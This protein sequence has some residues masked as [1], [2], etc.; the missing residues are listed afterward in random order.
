[1]ENKIIIFG[2]PVAKQRAR[3]VNGRAF[4][5]QKTK[6]Y[7][8]K[9]AWEYKR[10]KGKFFGDKPVKVKIELFFAPPKS[11]TKK[12]LEKIANGEL[13]FTG[14]KDID[15]IAKSILD[16]LNGIA[17][18]DDRQVVELSIRKQYTLG[19]TRA[20]IGINEVE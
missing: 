17:Y 5:P 19:N 2:E 9:V 16:G 11:I 14:K 15:N 3:V 1:M 4:T 10:Q 7:E 12:N 13:F 20:E 6:D 8:N 18:I